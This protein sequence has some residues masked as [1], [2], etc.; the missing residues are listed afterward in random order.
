[1]H[2]QKVSLLG[3]GLLG[4]SIG[5]AL[6]KRKLAARIEGFVR[7]DASI[8]ECES[9]GVVDRASRDLATVV[10]DADL[11]ILCTP[12]A[13]MRELTAQFT[14]HLKRGA[15]VTDVGSV[16]ASVVAELE[17]PV[18]NAGGIFIGSHPM[19]G[20]EAAGPKAARADLFEGAACVLTP[21]ARSTPAALK[22]LDEFWSALGAR[23]LRL[24]PEIHDDLVARCSHLPHVVAAELANYVLS[25]AHPKEQA[26]LC[27]NGFRDT[28]RIASG[29]TEM[30]RDIALANRTK[31]ARVLGVFIEDLQELQLAL[32]RGDARAIEEFFETAK[33]RRDAWVDGGKSPE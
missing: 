29:S 18:A 22:Q 31:L 11:V 32:E 30:W 26:L 14:P 7:R 12:L 25:P 16:K 6:K 2:F 33:V 20:S 23:T 27:A 10:K 24:S 13:Q 9:L 19:A 17:G 3:V 21:N 4:G 28:T 15:L 8:A 1:M 5:L